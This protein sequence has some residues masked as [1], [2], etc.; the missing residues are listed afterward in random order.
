MNERKLV[1][2]ICE[3]LLLRFTWHAAN[4]VRIQATFR[5]RFTHAYACW[6]AIGV[7]Q[8]GT[9]WDSTPA[10]WS[11]AECVTMRIPRIHQLVSNAEMKDSFDETIK[12]VG[13]F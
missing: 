5:Q 2:P 9:W 4:A 3:S 11:I 7:S 12:S 6:L 10:A 1:D 13:D 8:T